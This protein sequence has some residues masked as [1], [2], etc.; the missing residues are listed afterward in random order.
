ML[1]FFGQKFYEV[2]S[3]LELKIACFAWG[4]HF[5]ILYQMRHEIFQFRKLQIVI[6]FLELSV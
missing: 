2:F 6:N 1:T 5:F 3:E 4:W